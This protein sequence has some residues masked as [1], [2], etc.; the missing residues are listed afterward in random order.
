MAGTAGDGHSEE[1]SLYQG[2]L[3]TRAIRRYTDEAVPDDALRDILFAATR[4]PSGSNP[5]PLRFIA[6]PGGRV[7]EE[8][9]RLM[10]EGPRR[11]WAAK[12]EADGYDSGSGA[13]A[14]SPKAR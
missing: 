10:G 3:T 1:V 5:Q 14:D 7:A 6:L 12:R 2:L 4:A 11:F 8:P 9:K 13:Q